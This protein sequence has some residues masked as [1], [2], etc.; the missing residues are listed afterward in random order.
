MYTSIAS[1]LSRAEERKIPLWEVVLEDDLAER[2]GWNGRR[3]WSG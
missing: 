1:M 3:P 2:G